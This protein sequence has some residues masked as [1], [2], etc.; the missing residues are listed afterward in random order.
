MSA[1][2]GAS[3]QLDQIEALADHALVAVEAMVGN[4]NQHGF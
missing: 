4:H 1:A 3:Q 2:A